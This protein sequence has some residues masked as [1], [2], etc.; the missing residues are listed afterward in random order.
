MIGELVVVVDVEPVVETDCDV[1]A[2]SVVV[3]TEVEVVF[4][5]LIKFHLPFY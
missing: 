3:G 2:I 5:S 4:K 1:V